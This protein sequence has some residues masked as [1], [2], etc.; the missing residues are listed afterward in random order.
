MIGTRIT[1]S[2]LSQV[3]KD[4][5][6]ALASDIKR[7]VKFW[8]ILKSAFCIRNIIDDSKNPRLYHCSTE[9][10][11][12]Y[13]MKHVRMYSPTNKFVVLWNELQHESNAKKKKHVLKYVSQFY[14]SQNAYT[15]GG[16]WA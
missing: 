15:S 3:Y 2:L 7:S 11:Y 10:A 4:D 16:Y 9:M 6:A 14:W 12:L 1:H 13:Y 8:T 5:V